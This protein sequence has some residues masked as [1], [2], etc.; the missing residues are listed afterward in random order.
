MLK[1]GYVSPSPGLTTPTTSGQCWNYATCPPSPGA[2]F[3]C[4]KN[5]KKC[6]AALLLKGK[7]CGAV[8]PKKTK[9]AACVRQ[10]MTKSAVKCQIVRCSAVFHFKYDNNVKI[11][12]TSIKLCVTKNDRLHQVC[13]MP[14]PISRYQHFPSHVTQRSHYFSTPTTNTFQVVVPIQNTFQV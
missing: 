12:K 11:D 6:G 14:L 3:K 13:R 2:M 7:N 5:A 9:S 1:L 8:R 4:G 10:K